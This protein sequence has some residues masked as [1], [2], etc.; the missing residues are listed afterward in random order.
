MVELCKVLVR[1]WGILQEPF[2]LQNSGFG[3]SWCLGWPWQVAAGAV[4]AQGCSFDSWVLSLC[5]TRARSVL[6]EPGAS[7]QLG[8]ASA[9][10]LARWWLS[11]AEA[12]KLQGIIFSLVS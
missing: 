5:L 9:S 6:Q 7:T 10:S 2:G 12:V 1:S 8:F 4:A 11:W 3:G